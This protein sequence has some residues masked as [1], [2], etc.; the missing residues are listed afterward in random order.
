VEGQQLLQSASDILLG[1]LS[2]E[3]LDG[4]RRD[5]YVR[6]LWDWKLSVDVESMEPAALKFYAQICAWTLA[7]AHAVSGDGVTIAAYLGNSDQF[8]EAIA[9]FAGAYAD[10]NQRDFDTVRAQRGVR[11]V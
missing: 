11:L 3:G 7:R 9:D 4:V 1:W 2:A 10:Q 6:Q 5:F 8:D